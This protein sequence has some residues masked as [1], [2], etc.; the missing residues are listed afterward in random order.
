[1]STLTKAKLALTVMGLILFFGGVRYDNETLRLAAIVL[2]AIAWVMRFVK[3]KG[4]P[5]DPSPPADEPGEG[6]SKEG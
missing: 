1:V 4:P 2:V 3:P 5:R 6:E